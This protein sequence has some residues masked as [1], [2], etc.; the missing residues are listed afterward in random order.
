MTAYLNQPFVADTLNR[1][2]QQVLDHLQECAVRETRARSPWL[3]WPFRST[4]P[5]AGRFQAEHPQPPITK[6]S[7]GNAA[8]TTR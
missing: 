5:W 8:A 3:V 1:R 7:S 2:E 6:T 4:R